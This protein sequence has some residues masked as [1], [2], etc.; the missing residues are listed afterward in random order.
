MHDAIP[1]TVGLDRAPTPTRRI[2]FLLS[3]LGKSVAAQNQERPARADFSETSGL[4]RKSLSGVSSSGVSSDCSPRTA[5]KAASIWTRACS[6]FCFASSLRSSTAFC[7]ERRSSFSSRQS[8]RNIGGMFFRKSFGIQ[9]E[10]NRGR[11]VPEYESL[12][13]WICQVELGSRKR[14]ASRL[15]PYITESTNLAFLHWAS[16]C[17]RCA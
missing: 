13:S 6:R 4:A 11:C 12:L 10:R 5:C 3:G 2:R 9:Q 8:D 17:R 14:P 16:F 15:V 1:E 7:S